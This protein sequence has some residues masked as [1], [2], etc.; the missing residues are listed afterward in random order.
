MWL[1]K[2]LL[3]HQRTSSE[4]LETTWVRSAQHFSPEH[5]PTALPAKP[6]AP[7]PGSFKATGVWAPPGESLTQWE[8]RGGGRERQ[9]SETPGDCVRQPGARA[10]PTE[11]TPSTRNWG[12]QT[13]TSTSDYACCLCFH[14]LKLVK[15]INGTTGVWIWHQERDIWVFLNIKNRKKLIRN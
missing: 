4:R 6:A 10:C 1:F 13:S 3:S 2:P 15:I 5:A 8:G 11:Q 14:L 12:L 7:P 9:S